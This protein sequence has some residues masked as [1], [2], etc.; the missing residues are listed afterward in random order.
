[1][2]G[3]REGG[4]YVGNTPMSTLDMAVHYTIDTIERK[5]KKSLK[6]S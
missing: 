4:G 3:Y 5:I 6:K 1:M 2:G